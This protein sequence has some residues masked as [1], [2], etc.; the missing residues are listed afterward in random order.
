MKRKR[1][2]KTRSLLSHA[3]DATRVNPVRPG[4][5]VPICD[6]HWR[7]LAPDIRP[8]NLRLARLQARG[9]EDP[10]CIAD[11]HALGLEELRSPSSQDEPRVN[12]LSLSLFCQLDERF[13]ALVAPRSP[14]ERR[15]VARM[16]E[17]LESGRVIAYDKA[18]SLQSVC[19]GRVSRFQQFQDVLCLAGSGRLKEILFTVA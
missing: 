14:D 12:L 11:S 18:K 7:L 6:V 4:S 13:S 19:I 5:V 1:L 15:D 3:A 16:Q 17:G 10:D 8:K 9:R 2:A